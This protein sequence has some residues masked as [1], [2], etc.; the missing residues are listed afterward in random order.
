M[1]EVTAE[2]G[3]E[4][5]Q[6]VVY[7]VVLTPDGVQRRRLETHPTARRAELSAAAINRTVARRRSRPGGSDE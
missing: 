7:L 2:I 3:Q 5:G 4:N 6:W 1:D